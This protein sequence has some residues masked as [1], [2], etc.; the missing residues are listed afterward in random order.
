MTTPTDTLREEHV[1]ILRALDAL[2]GA[3][4]RLATGRALPAG[5]WE[6]MIAWLRAFADRNHHGKEEESLFPAM[7][8]AGAP[9][10]GGP[11]DVMLDE[12]VE[13]RALIQ[14]MASGPPGERARTAQRYVEFLRD[15]ID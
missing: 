5:W 7:L 3:A 9:S 1:V 13:G 12:H 6:E 8:K 11:I 14:A 4:E 15:Q 10:P 2:A